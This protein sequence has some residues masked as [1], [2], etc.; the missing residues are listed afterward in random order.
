M[1][2]FLPLNILKEKILKMNNLEFANKVFDY[3]FR[4][5]KIFYLAGL[6]DYPPDD[7]INFIENKKYLPHKTIF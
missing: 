4:V 7:F 6:S 3:G 1:A 5:E 2:L